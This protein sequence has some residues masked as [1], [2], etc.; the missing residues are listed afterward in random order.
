MSCLYES[1]TLDT[2][3]RKASAWIARTKVEVEI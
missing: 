3:I 1:E 2:C